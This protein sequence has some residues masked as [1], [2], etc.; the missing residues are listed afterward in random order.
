MN[1]DLEPPAS[2]RKDEVEMTTGQFPIGQRILLPGHFVQPVTLEA[3]RRIGSSYECRVRLPDG[4]PDEAI[5]TAEEASS[6]VGRKTETS[7]LLRPAE[8]EKIRLLV[9]SVRI[10]FAY[11]HDHQFAVSLPGI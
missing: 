7:P 9:E 5:I 4:T 6:L 3:V 2:N 1:S 11:A 10:R 8:A